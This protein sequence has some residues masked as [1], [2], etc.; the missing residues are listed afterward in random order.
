MVENTA[1]SWA[2]HTFNPWIGCTKISPACDFCYAE[3]LASTR[4]K[5]PELWQGELRRTAPSTWGQVHRWNRA[6]AAKGEPCFVFTASLADIMDN[7]APQEWRD[8]LWSLTQQTPAL[9]WL[10]L[11]KR[12]S[13]I[14]KMVPSAWLQRGE[15]PRN[16]IPGV[17]CADQ[18]EANQ[19]LWILA[20]LAA[21][22]GARW[23]MSGEPLLGAI[24]LTRV[25]I[26]GT[27]PGLFNALTGNVRHYPLNDHHGVVTIDRRPLAPM[28]LAIGGGESGAMALPIRPSHP[29]WFRQMRDQCAAAGVPFHFKQWGEWVGGTYT[30]G[31]AIG[32]TVRFP[33]GKTYPAHDFGDGYFAARMGKKVT[34]RHLDNVEHLA[35]PA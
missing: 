28:C 15:W 1:I 7:Q 31:E 33:D 3:V 27:Q 25:A 29:D 30:G 12:P 21:H 2:Q 17:T 4:M 13:N 18:K 22:T 34:G 35:M 8:D 6:A 20:M 11:T 32:D 16:V 23:F 5:S 9:T 14:P 26:P 24:D 10:P 19:N